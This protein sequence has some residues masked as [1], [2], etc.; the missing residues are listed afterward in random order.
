MPGLATAA[1]LYK[2]GMFGDA[3]AQYTE[4]GRHGD[5]YA[6]VQAAAM[7]EEGKGTERNLE[8]ARSLY[9]KAA[10]SDG[11]YA[12]YR[13]AKFLLSNGQEVDAVRLMHSLMQRGYLPAIYWLGKLQTEGV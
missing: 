4:L 11:L 1:E 7:V 9:E 8:L 3:Y 13:Y 2:R 12:N 6:I 5:V 10:K